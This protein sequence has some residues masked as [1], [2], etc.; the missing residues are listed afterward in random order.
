MK[1]GCMSSAQNPLF[2]FMHGFVLAYYTDW[3][4]NSYICEV[5]LNHQI[6]RVFNQLMNL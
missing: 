3:H 1:E 2:N 4:R 5:L 6:Y